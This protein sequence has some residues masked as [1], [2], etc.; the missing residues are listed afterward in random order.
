MTV[1][2]IEWRE[3][4]SFEDLSENDRAYV[5][6][7]DN[8]GNTYVIFGDGIK[9]RLPAA[10]RENIKAKYRVGIGFEGILAADQLSLLMK[11]P[12]GIR[13]VINPLSTVGGADAEK[14]EDAR[15]NAPRTVLTLDRIVSLEDF[16]SFAQGFAG[17]GKA[18]SY[19][20]QLDGTD[21]VVV[22]VASSDGE[23][24]CSSSDLYLNLVDAIELYKDPST[25]FLVR[26]FN[27]RLFDIRAKILVASDRD[28]EETRVKVKDSLKE[29]F[30]FTNRPFGLAVT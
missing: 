23:I 22:A 13:S 16:R 6:H 25:P 17:V 8:E 10:G 30:S 14:L 9:G 19:T 20:V 24:V 1:D 12:L 28:F 27:K 11:K 5:T 29:T 4:I 21:I 7:T 26:S 3:A 15:I 18:T 2:G